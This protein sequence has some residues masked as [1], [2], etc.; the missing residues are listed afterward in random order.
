MVQVRRRVFEKTFPVEGYGKYGCV[1]TATD[2]NGN[3][4]CEHE[5]AVVLLWS[6]EYE[7]FPD[8]EQRDALRKVC[9]VSGGAVYENIE[10]LMQAEDDAQTIEYDPTNGLAAMG[11]ACV[12]AALLARRIPTKRKDKHI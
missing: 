1:L 12:C 8:E 6:S 11:L 10:A 4:I 9:E 7:A 2:L 5:T 3:V